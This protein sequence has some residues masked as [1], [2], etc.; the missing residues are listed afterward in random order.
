MNTVLTHNHNH[1]FYHLYSVTDQTGKTQKISNFSYANP[2]GPNLFEESPQTSLITFQKKFSGTPAQIALSSVISNMKVGN[3]VDLI[4][5]NDNK[6]KSE[7]GRL[8]VANMENLDRGAISLSDSFGMVNPGD[9][10]GGVFYNGYLIGNIWAIEPGFIHVALVP[11]K[12]TNKSIA[13]S[14]VEENPL[15]YLK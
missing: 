8:K 2:V 5:W 11:N 13:T 14:K 10:G 9:S 6:N 1:T 4:F 15:K 3:L 12:I 7:V